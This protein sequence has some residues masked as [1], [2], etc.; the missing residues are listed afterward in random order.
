[1][2]DI[3]DQLGAHAIGLTM[4]R[5]TFIQA[6]GATGAGLSGPLGL[7]DAQRPETALL[8]L[9]EDSSRE[10]LPRELVR[11]IRAGLRYQE[12]LAALCWAAV[13]NVQ[14]YPDV[15][16]KYHSVMVLRSINATT[17]HL[18]P[19]ERWLPI[20]W[21]ADYF[22]SAQAQ[23]RTT[24]AWHLPARRATSAG[25]AQAARSRLIAALD[26]WDRDAADSAIV[27]YAAVASTDE[28]FSLLF[29]YGARDLREIGHKAIAVANAHSLL[30]LLGRSQGEAVLR[31]TV[32]ALQN[33]DASPNPASH[34]LESDRPWR[35]N[36][37]RLREI[38][39]SWEQ[40]RN[41]PAART[42]LRSELY[43]ASE[44]EAGT[45]IIAML[46]QAISPDA[47]WQV[48]FDTAAEFMMAQPGILSVHAQ[49]TANALHYAYRIC[50][51]EPTRQLL[52]LQCAAFIALFRRYTGASTSDFNLEALQSLPLH[53]PD[54]DAIDELYAEVSAG[55]RPQTAAKALAYLQGGG[56][57]EALIARARHYFVYYAD[58]P[59]DYK[60]P[61][62]V[63]EN[64]TQ[65]ADGAWRRRFLSAGM[66][67]FKAP[68][69]RPGPIVQETL[70][71][72][73][74]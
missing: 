8:T 2:R 71:L 64:Y 53:R 38:P 42:E 14:P 15:G 28:I 52:L 35:Q 56:D 23:E 70:E 33:S 32:A 63:F 26:N 44:Q 39:A 37:Q 31:S 49:T 51:S 58:E 74:A 41:D 59:H 50:D 5:R 45:A 34:D 48:L 1:L 19:G 60:F 6:A 54:A 57:P 9:L 30:A 72:L 4:D 25:G 73:Q 66:A 29:A 16:Y 22:K 46:R 21:A 17:Q 40:G 36:R 3:R 27:N 67:H 13:R 20:V 43:R 61:E 10:Q 18:S 11:R 7:T 65:L 55:R 12:L 68:A 47:I 69:Q 24:S 62:A